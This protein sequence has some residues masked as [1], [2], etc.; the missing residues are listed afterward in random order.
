MQFTSL[1]QLVG[2]CRERSVQKL[3][4]KGFPGRIANKNHLMTLSLSHSFSFFR[5]CN[6]WCCNPVGILRGVLKRSKAPRLLRELCSNDTRQGVRS[7]SP[8][9]ALSAMQG[10][11]GREQRRNSVHPLLPPSFPASREGSFGAIYEVKLHGPHPLSQQLHHRW[12]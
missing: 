4:P 10:A 1:P 5:R 8:S 2:S 3:F 7:L 11:I 9:A 6:E 12:F